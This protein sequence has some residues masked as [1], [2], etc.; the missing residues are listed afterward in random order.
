M[1]TL[2]VRV[3]K[4]TDDNPIEL[5]T[6]ENGTLLLSTVAALFPGV[7]GLK[8]KHGSGFRVLKL[9]NGCLYPPEDRWGQTSYYCVFPESKSNLVKANIPVFSQIHS[10]NV[11]FDIF[12]AYNPI[13]V[14]R[15]TS[16]QVDTE[17]QVIHPSI[18][19]CVRP[20]EKCQSCR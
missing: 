17:A 10:F 13:C 11:N 18:Y 7:S 8:F 20:G 19:I 15:P 3:C 4:T 14:N 2:Y 16:S 5:P 6:E 12:A 9:A 1:T